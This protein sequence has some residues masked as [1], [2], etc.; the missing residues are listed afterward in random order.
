MS[1]QTHSKPPTVKEHSSILEKGVVGGGG[2][3][4]G[5]GVKFKKL[6]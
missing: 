5:G 3:G 6:E 4:G 2:G 1:G